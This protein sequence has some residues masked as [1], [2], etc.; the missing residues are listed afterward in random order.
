MLVAGV[1][2]W[3]WGCYLSA[4][5][6]LCAMQPAVS[7]AGEPV[8]TTLQRVESRRFLGAPAKWQPPTKYI[9]LRRPP[10]VHFARYP[11]PDAPAHKWSHWGPG[12]VLPDGRVLTSLGDHRAIDGNS[13]LYLYDPRTRV[14]RLAADLQSA[15][16]GFQAGDF[17][18]GKIHDRLNLAADG[19]VYFSSFWGLRKG[20]SDKFAGERLFRFEPRTEELTDLGRPVD[21]WGFPSSNFSR[22]HNLYYAE[23][24]YRPDYD[25]QTHGMRFL[26]YDV[27]A[28]KVRFFGGHE[29]TGYGRDLFVDADGNAWFNNGKQTL[30]KY[31]PATNRLTDAGA[32]MPVSRLRRTAGPDANGMLYATSSDKNADGHRVLFRFDPRKKQT[33][34]IARLWADAPAMALHPG[35]RWIY[36]V[37]GNV[38]YPGR[39]LLRVNVNDGAVEVIAFLQAAI[40]E[41]HGFT[42]GGTYSLCV[43][44]DRAYV[45]FGLNN[46]LALVVVSIPE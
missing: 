24:A 34:T 41:Q 11:M 5:L 16:D 4:V 26:A 3:T 8:Q 29:G 33:E 37:P 15:V 36:M 18:F 32:V 39:P 17:G 9:V 12:T 25:N 1:V 21:D 13:Y 38:S 30:V 27:R 6:A 45:Q 14:L 22:Q 35:G 31:D 7:L 42:L 23:A 28:R 44:E 43:D 46:D 10:A 20:L 40:K 2:R 19:S